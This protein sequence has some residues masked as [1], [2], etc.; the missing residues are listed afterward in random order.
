ML[1]RTVDGVTTQFAYSDEWQD[2]LTSVN[3]TELTYDANGNL[4]SYGDI[5]YSWKQGKQLETITDGEN[6]YTYKYDSNGIRLSKTVNGYKTSFDVFNG[7]ILAQYD[8][9]NDI[10]F[11]YYNEELIGFQL[12]NVQYFYVTNLSGDIV[13]ITDANGNLIAEYSY[14]E[15]GKLLEIK[16]EEEGNAQQLKVAQANPFRYRGYYYD[17]ETGMYYLQSRYYNPELCRFISA[18]DFRY[19]DSSTQLGINAYSYCWN[20]PVAFDDA[21]GTTPDLSINLADIV[22]FI[23]NVNNQIKNDISGQITSLTEKLNKLTE[24]WKNALKIRYNS[25]IDNLE[26]AINYPDAV[27]N[28]TLSKALNKD[29]NIRFRLIELLRE[30]ANLQFD[31]SKLKADVDEN[32]TSTNLKKSKSRKTDSSCGSGMGSPLY[33]IALI[34]TEIF[35]ALDV[36]KIAGDLDLSFEFSNFDEYIKVKADIYYEANKKGLLSTLGNISSFFSGALNIF[37]SESLSNLSNSLGWVGYGMSTLS[38]LTNG[39]LSKSGKARVMTYD[40]GAAFASLIVVSTVATGGA[41][42]VPIILA[43]AGTSVAGYFIHKYAEKN[44]YSSYL[45]LGW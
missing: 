24:N 20:C 7:K 16:T 12:E 34:I 19:I 15:W 6:T 3:D 45:E 13:G 31:L 5:S 33:T 28:N 37:P 26:Y 30:Q 11:Q 21:E 8:N 14:D 10:Y 42:T 2:Q 32:I 9:H 43:V 39:A 40:L 41:G 18:D 35:V 1:S 22:S 23:Q 27:I 17:T 38:T 29:V 44:S 4:L 36:E 25:F